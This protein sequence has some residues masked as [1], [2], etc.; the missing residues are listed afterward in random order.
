MNLAHN[1]CFNYSYPD[2]L[3]F[4]LISETD[5]FWVLP[6]LKIML[7]IVIPIRNDWKDWF[8]SKPHKIYSNS[9]LA[10]NFN[11]LMETFFECINVKVEEYNK[12]L[13]CED[14]LTK[15]NRFAI[16]NDTIT[17]GDLGNNF[18]N[19]FLEYKIK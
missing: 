13:S 1:P 19:N 8:D 18:Y 12:R 2:F 3:V 11:L 9:D 15:M 6:Y 4:H 16:D 5:V 17:R 14:L 7:I 10:E